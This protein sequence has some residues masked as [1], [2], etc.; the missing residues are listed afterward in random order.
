MVNFAK[1][2]LFV[3]TLLLAFVNIVSGLKVPLR[4]L[5]RNAEESGID[6]SDLKTNA[7]RLRFGFPLM[8]PRNLSN[9]SKTLEART[10]K[11]SPVPPTPG[12]DKKCLKVIKKNKKGQHEDVGFVAKDTISGLFKVKDKKK[13]CLQVS[14]PK[15]ANAPFDITIL[16]ERGAKKHL[17]LAGEDKYSSVYLVKTAQTGANSRPKKV[18]NSSDNLPYSESTVWSYDANSNKLSSVWWPKN[19]N[20]ISVRTYLKEKD[21]KNLLH[22]VTKNDEFTRSE[23]DE[24]EV[25]LQPVDA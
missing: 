22:F 20:K 23:K 18:G 13:E 7:E 6:V 3:A 1:S 9:P 11:H 10:G 16:D 24:Y 2:G 19:G 8:K 15:K 4:Q 25:W 14:V 5:R 21:S 12:N 17:G